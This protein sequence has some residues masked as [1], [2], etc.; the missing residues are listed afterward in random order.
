MNQL[1]GLKRPLTNIF[2]CLLHY[3][4]IV[5]KFRIGIFICVIIILN[6]LLKNDG[7]Y[8]ILCQYGL[9]LLF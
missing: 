8:I 1:N 4:L 6:M 7:V 9:T 3:F 2:I 5:C